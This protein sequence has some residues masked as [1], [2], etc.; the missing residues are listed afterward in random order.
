MSAK[1]ET[2]VPPA[3]HENADVGGRFIASAFALLIVS[4]AVVMVC[5]L[6]LFPFPNTDRTLNTPLPFYPEPRLQPS[7]RQEMQRF[8]A[9]ERAQLTSYGWVDKSHGIV[10]LPVDVA[11]EEIARRGISDWPTASG[12]SAKNAAPSFGPTTAMDG[13][14]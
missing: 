9:E 7:P 4:L 6:W 1:A 13:T 11:M 14:R 2:I 3:G 12:Q 8:L 5:V 10:R